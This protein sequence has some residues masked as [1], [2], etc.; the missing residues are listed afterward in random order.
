VEFPST[1][2]SL[3][4]S[5]QQRSTFVLVCSA[6]YDRTSY[7]NSHHLACDTVS[8]EPGLTFG[9]FGLESEV[10]ISPKVRKSKEEEE[11]RRVETTQ[12]EDQAP[13]SLLCRLLP[14]SHVKEVMGVKG[15]GSMDAYSVYLHPEAEQCGFARTDGWALLSTVVPVDGARGAE[16]QRS[17]SS[18]RYPS[19]IPVTMVIDTSVPLGHTVVGRG[20]RLSISSAPFECVVLSRFERGMEEMIDVPRTVSLA[21]VGRSYGTSPPPTHKAII[22]AFKG[23]SNIRFGQTF[24]TNICG[25]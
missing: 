13:T 19:R 3:C 9:T 2:R 20:L 15:D 7:H 8:I 12:E 18:A 4:G 17:A 1:S 6:G 11:P 16:K 25:I 10:Y 23:R 14:M 21:V 24:Q 22:E 5:L